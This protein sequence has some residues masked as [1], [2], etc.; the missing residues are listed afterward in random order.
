MK[1][2]KGDGEY[3]AQWV[4]GKKKKKDITARNRKRYT[5][6]NKINEQRPLQKLAVTIPTLHDLWIFFV[7]VIFPLTFQLLLWSWWKMVCLRHFDVIKV[8]GVIVTKIVQVPWQ[9][10]WFCGSQLPGHYN[11]LYTLLIMQ[12]WFRI[13]V[14]NTELV[15][16][17]CNAPKTFAALVT[18]GY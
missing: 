15:R 3:I 11:Q 5:S 16:I 1:G 8:N 10:K 6:E 14:L 18:P 12:S 17:I 2:C 4:R 9:K 7:R 13:L